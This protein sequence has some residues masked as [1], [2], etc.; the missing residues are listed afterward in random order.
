MSEKTHEELDLTDPLRAGI[1][2]L[3]FML[4]NREGDLPKNVVDMIELIIEQE[5]KL[6]YASSKPLSYI[7]ARAL[8][9]LCRN[10]FLQWLLNMG[11][12]K[13]KNEQ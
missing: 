1:Y 6:S 8:L 7:S 11:L 10:F 4:L 5:R 12:I 9:S 13:V 3:A 2:S